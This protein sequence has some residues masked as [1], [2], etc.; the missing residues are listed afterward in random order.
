G[1]RCWVPKLVF[2]TSKDVFTVMSSGPEQEPR[3]MWLPPVYE[4]QKLS[5][6]NLWAAICSNVLELLD[7]Q[8]IKHSSIDL[9][10]F[11]R[12]KVNDINVAPYGTVVTTPVMI[13]VG[14]LLE[15]WNAI[16]S[17]S[18]LPT[19]SSISSRTMVFLTLMLHTVSRWPGASMVLNCS[20]PS[21]ILIAVVA[22]SMMA[23]HRSRDYCT[24]PT[25][26]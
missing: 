18:T 13:W 25:Y 7:Q 20:H 4:H 14:V 1:P 9:V 11:S 22:R 24:W 10:R 23:R 17:H 15:E 2:R 21:R 19:K 12:V 16:S 5:K 26:R 6:D 3:R 8:K